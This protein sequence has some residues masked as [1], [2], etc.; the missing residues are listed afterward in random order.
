MIFPY[1]DYY[2]QYKGVFIYMQGVMCKRILNKLRA[3]L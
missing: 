1:N 3:R 2:L